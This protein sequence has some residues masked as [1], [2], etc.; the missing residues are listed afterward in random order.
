MTSHH[1]ETD[2]SCVFRN[3]ITTMDIKRWADLQDLCYNN[4]KI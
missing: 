3:L 4:T 2:F 1:C